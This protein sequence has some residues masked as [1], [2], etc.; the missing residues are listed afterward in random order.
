MPGK[1]KQP[2][3]IS[4][5]SRTQLTAPKPTDPMFPEAKNPVLRLPA[6]F[7]L[8]TLKLP[9]MDEPPTINLERLK[10][11][12]PWLT[13][14]IMA[15]GIASFIPLSA[16]Y[17]N[18]SNDHQKSNRV[19]IIPDMDNQPRW[20][21]Q[22]ANYLFADHRASRPW[23]DGTVPATLP[24]KDNHFD[25]GIV[26]G[27]WATGLP[28]QLEIN[29]ALLD[30][31][32]ERYNIYC[33]PCHGR[34]GYGDGSVAKHADRLKE[35]TWTVPLSYH[36]AQVRTRPV[37][38]IF[39]TITNGIRTMP[40]YGTQIPAADRWAIIAWIRVLQASQDADINSLPPDQQQELLKRKPKVEAPAQPPSGAVGA[41]LA[42]PAAQTNPGGASSTPTET[43]GV[44]GAY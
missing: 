40:P 24:L 44:G 42:P 30:R 37:G 36:T 12:I 32:R 33:A 28:P 3:N 5:P 10:R 43:P 4:P 31:G 6:G 35:G 26:D 13:P 38:H 39:N 25:Y 2:K 27:A 29:Q 7:K 15:F 22:Q 21:S 8:P 9:F 18:R 20:K 19:S 17:Y 14:A 41:A 34:G 1:K 16:I 11:K 23:P